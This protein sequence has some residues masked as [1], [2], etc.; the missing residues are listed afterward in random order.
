MTHTRAVTNAGA[1]S[2]ILSNL[3]MNSIKHGFEGIEQGNIA[4]FVEQKGDFTII[5]YADDGIGLDDAAM[6]MLFE[7]FYTTKRGTGG[8]GLGTHLVYNLATSALGGRIEA[9][10]ELGK[11]LAYLIKFPTHLE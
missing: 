7:P 5:R 3:I 6:N 2:Q 8:S 1:V 10:S 4:I 11:G 9:K